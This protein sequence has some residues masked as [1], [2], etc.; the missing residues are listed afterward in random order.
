MILAETC[1]LLLPGYNVVLTDYGIYLYVLL[2]VFKKN[3]V[4]ICYA[5][6]QSTT[7]VA[8]RVHYRIV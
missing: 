8:V 1:S 4:R 3:F 2:Q 5:L 6:Y 7:F